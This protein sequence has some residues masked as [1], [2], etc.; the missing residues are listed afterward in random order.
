[1]RLTDRPTWKFLEWQAQSLPSGPARLRWP[2]QI[3]SDLLVLDY[4]AQRM[5]DSGLQGLIALANDC[6]LPHKIDA[7]LSGQ[8]VN[9]SENKPAFHSLLRA[10]EGS[11]LVPMHP[12]FEQVAH[13]RARMGDIAQTIREGRWLGSTGK[14]ITAVVNIGIGGSHLGPQ[15]TVNAL[16]SQVIDTLSFHFLSSRDP[17]A[18]ER[19]TRHLSPETT[20]FIVS[21]KSFQT[22]ET[23]EHAREAMAWYGQSGALAQH[24]IA[25]TAE[26]GRA[27]ALGLE[28]VLPIWDWVGGR[29]SMCSAINLI[30][31][32][33]IG[34]EE[35]VEL[36]RGAHAM[37]QHFRYREFDQNIPVLMALLGIWNNNFLHRHQLLILTYAHDLQ[38]LTAYIQ[39]LDMESNGKSVDEQGRRVNYATGP[40]VWGGLGNLAQHSYYQLLC[41]GTHQFAADLVSIDAFDGHLVNHMCAAHRQVLSQGVSSPDL[42]TSI[43]GHVPLNH[44]RLKNNGPRALGELIAAYEH[45]IFVQGVIWNI[46]SFDQPGVESA[47]ILVKQAMQDASRVESLV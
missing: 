34:F 30:T 26:P 25:V 36:L 8:V 37:D 14:P 31:C 20:L 7:L 46:N 11:K 16:A 12:W 45:K 47:K 2:R 38:D 39:Q 23:L 19:V 28:H 33:A 29:F 1:M 22:Q 35:F 15:F 42:H 13:T 4:A 6:Q 3:E 41:Q 40:M 24:F 18:F 44:L 43:A 21:S 17:Y 5:D 32:I 9:R 27:R 10:F